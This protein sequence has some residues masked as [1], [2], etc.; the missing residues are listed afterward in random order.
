[1]KGTIIATTV[2]ALAVHAGGAAEYETPRTSFGHPDLEGI[3]TNATITSLERPQWMSDLTISEEEAAQM[4]ERTRRMAEAGLQPTD[5]DAP[6]PEAGGNVGGYNSFW[7]DAGTTVA[8]VRGEYRSSLVVH[9]ADGRIP[10]SEEGRAK[11]AEATAQTQLQEH[12]EQRQIGERCLVGYGST[13]GPPMVP[14]LYNNN[15]QIIQT[16]DYVVIQVEMNNDARIIPLDRDHRGTP[17]WLGDSVGYWDGDTLVVETTNFQPEERLRPATRHRLYMSE[18]ARITERFTRTDPDQIVYEFTVDDPAVYT[19]AWRG[20]IPLMAAEGPIYEY[21][22][23]EG[24]YALPGILAGAR[25]EEQAENAEG[26][27]Q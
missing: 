9:P 1:M 11:M 18:G 6:A 2:L 26:G 3:W 4:E 17:R 22:C 14:V 23:H 8:R 19:E 24:N 27:S 21:A 20:E 10:W 16:P 13:G 12:P 25:A 15:Y 5:P 7:I